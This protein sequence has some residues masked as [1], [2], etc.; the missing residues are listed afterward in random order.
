MD[1][2]RACLD[3]FDLFILLVELFRFKVDDAFRSP[4]GEHLSLIDNRSHLMP[5]VLVVLTKL[6]IVR[7]QF[8]RGVI[9]LLASNVF[10]DRCDI[11]MTD[12]SSISGHL[13]LLIEL[14]H[15]H[16]EPRKHTFVHKMLLEPPDHLI[17]EFLPLGWLNGLERL[18][19]S[20]LCGAGTAD[21]RG[22]L[23]DDCQVDNLLGLSFS[24]LLTVLA[25]LLDRCVIGCQHVR[26][27]ESIIVAAEPP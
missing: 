6:G 11:L 7:D 17:V 20:R 9:A 21:T 22:F 2:L 26:C 15:D 27:D 18:H 3:L 16:F 10:S 12:C 4:I 25:V 13:E 24:A 8:S 19:V 14:K 23:A 1:T 5:I